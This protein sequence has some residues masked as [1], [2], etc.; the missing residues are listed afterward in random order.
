MGEVF[1]CW[2]AP[3]CSSRIHFSEETV[4][5]RIANEMRV[6][7]DLPDLPAPNTKPNRNQDRTTEI[8]SAPSTA[9]LL[10]NLVTVFN[11]PERLFG[12]SRGPAR[13][14][15]CHVCQPDF[16]PDWSI[17]VSGQTEFEI[18]SQSST[19]AILNET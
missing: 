9:A 18:F 15:T 3:M 6:G 10:F 1:D 12:Q 8:G 14:T 17:N 19:R 16:V 7:Q 13:R 2:G 5:N 4:N 11:K